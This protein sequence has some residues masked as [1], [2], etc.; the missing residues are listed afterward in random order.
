M[1][2]RETAAKGIQARLGGSRKRW[3]ARFSSHAVR[4]SQISKIRRNI[5]RFLVI[6][7]F[8][9][10]LSP[11]FKSCGAEGSVSNYFKLYGW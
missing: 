7:A 8:K 4:Q 6:F 5:T 2:V 11:L 1:A 3:L 9:D 10:L